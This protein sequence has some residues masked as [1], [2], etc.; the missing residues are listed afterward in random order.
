MKDKKKTNSNPKLQKVE[1]VTP[2]EMFYGKLTCEC[3]WAKHETAA[4]GMVTILLWAV[5]KHT[6]E[7]RRTRNKKNITC[8]K[9][10][11]TGER[12]E[13]P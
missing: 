12:S 11:F 10:D 3:V 9:S 13:P 2:I 1:G 8:Y 5:N 4:F 6:S 7:A